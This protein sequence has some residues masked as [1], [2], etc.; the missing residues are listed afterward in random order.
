MDSSVGKRINSNTTN[1]IINSLR[2][3]T[4]YWQGRTDEL[5]QMQQWIHSDK[6][7]LIG[8]TAAGGYG[9]S[10][11]VAKLCEQLTDFPQQIW[12]TFSDAYPFAV[13]GRWL[14]DELGKPAPEKPEDL[15]IAV[16]NCLQTERYLLVLDNLETLLQNEQERQT[17]LQFLL[18]WFSSS[19]K[20]VIL[21]TSREKPT[22]PNN[23]LNQ[24]HWLPL[25]GLSPNAGVELLQALEI[26]GSE[27][28]LVAFVNQT[29]GHP[30]LLKLVAGWLKAEEGEE[31]DISLLQADIFDILG[32][33]QGNPEMSIA[34]I[35]DASLQLLEPSLQNWLHYL[36]VYRLAFDCSA[37]MEM[38]SGNFAD[39]TEV[40]SQLRKLAKRS[41]LQE[42]K[43]Q[44]VWKFYFPPL[45]Q[46][47]LQKLSSPAAHEYAIAYYEKCRKPQ[48]L[49]TDKLDDVA[50]YLE[51]FHH[52]CE[53]G[54]Y[55]QAFSSIYY[56]ENNHD[57]CDEFLRKNYYFP[58]RLT[59]YEHLYHEWQQP[60][61]RDE[62]KRYSDLLQVY[63]DVLQFLNRRDEAL[64]HYEDALKFY[65][66][67][68]DRLGEANTLKAIGDVLQFL[69]RSD[70]ALERYQEALKFYRDIG[71]RLGEANTLQA[72][73]DVLQFLKRSNEALEHYQ[74]ALKFYR[75]IGDRLGEANTLQ[76]IGDVLQFLKRSNE[77]LEH[78]Q[79]AL[80][81]YRDIGARLG[82][83]NTL[84]AIGDVLQFLKRSDEAL[85]RYQD[86]LKFYRDI[87]DRLGEANVLQEFGKLQ[88]EP[89]SALKY[90][91]S[92]QTLYIQIGSV[93]SQSRNLLFIADIQS[94]MADLDGAINSLNDAA[95]L[96]STINY[97]PFQEYAQ[98]RIAIINSLLSF[99]A[100]IASW[101]DRLKH[102]FEQRW[103][104]L[105]LCFLLG[106]ITF[107]LLRR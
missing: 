14:L 27:S 8:V 10:A 51:I 81:F 68:G 28:D 72:I 62:L 94:K 9:K 41:L 74:D 6:V 4:S 53:L 78:Y 71:D 88:P 60:E 67:I 97:Q 101:K 40:K 46:T 55:I 58:I 56:C 21:L 13:W 24:S 52:H 5:G 70:E 19:S 18:H 31:A 98:K 20:S 39:E 33:H 1:S 107:L 54:E 36:S 49:T 48:L 47:Y 79:D 43:Q 93:Y 103:L 90:L 89:Q 65:R 63:G 91:Q 75:E 73:G 59:L 106:L 7:R 76:A 95:A 64:E 57:N 42:K 87:G 2:P 23:T 61:N 80:K 83:A 84:Q 37:A 16:C 25:S 66:E 22:L 12:T 32:L 105:A 69:K 82:E 104:K 11:L 38:S 102:L 15:L 26:Q 99:F 45:I 50:E 100:L 34:K 17:Y 85:E 92:A 30:L 44:G 96:A 35:L 3:N 86:A 29:D 77:A